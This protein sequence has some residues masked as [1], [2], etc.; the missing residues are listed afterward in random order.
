MEPAE[1]SVGALVVHQLISTLVRR[2]REISPSA[3]KGGGGAVECNPAWYQRCREKQRTG[4]CDSNE[5]RAHAITACAC[6]EKHVQQHRR[7]QSNLRDLQDGGDQL[8]AGRAFKRLEPGR[9]DA[10]GVHL[11]TADDDGRDQEEGRY[12]CRK[13]HGSRPARLTVEDL[14]LG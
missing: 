4:D 3:D 7:K 5:G 9:V 8:L 14:L 2:K 6:R 12:K 10:G 1:D 13:R 11:A